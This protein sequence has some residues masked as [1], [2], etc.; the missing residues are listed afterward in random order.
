MSALIV[1]NTQTMHDSMAGGL[2]PS[3]PVLRAV[4]PGVL[5][6]IQGLLSLNAEI[7]RQSAM[8]AYVDD[9]RLMFVITLICIPM[10][11][12]MRG[13]QPRTRG[14]PVHAAE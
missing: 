8:V 11:L 4:A 3:N 10:L 2:D 14:E 13:P 1:A 12:I 9:F 7:T 5:S 6:S